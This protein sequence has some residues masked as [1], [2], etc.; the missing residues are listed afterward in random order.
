A[1]QLNN[2]LSSQ[3]KNVEHLF[4]YPAVCAAF[5]KINS[6]LPSSAAVERLFSV[7]GQ[8]FTNKRKVV[9]T[10]FFLNGNVWKVV[11]Y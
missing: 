9:N 10:S 3:A 5:L 6:K 7:A 8:I 4:C 11:N 2:Y 1:E